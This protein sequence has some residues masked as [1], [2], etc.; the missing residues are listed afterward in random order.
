MRVHFVG[1]SDNGL[2][3]SSHN[4]QAL[5]SIGVSTAF[6]PSESKV[7]WRS[8]VWQETCRGADV[9]HVVT[10]SQCN[11]MLLRKL[12]RARM[13]GVQMVRYWV[14]S[15]C[16]WARHHGPSRRFAQALGHLGT[17][18]LT[19]ADHLVAELAAIGV[20]AHT[21]PVITPNISASVSPHPMPKEF[22]ALCYLPTRRRAF[23][24]GAVIDRLIK[25]MP[26]VRFI[27][28]G[29]AA[30][31]YSRFDNVESPG[32]VDNLART[33]G[34]SSVY[35]RPTCHDGMPRLILEA[36][37]HGRHVVASRPYPHCQHAK[38]ADE[39]QRALRHL[40]GRAEFNL[41]GRE[42]V[43]QHFETRVTAQVLGD[44]LRRCLEPGRSGLRRTGRRQ[45]VA[46]IRRTE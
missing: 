28:L 26:T 17:L 23:Y 22:A 40:E 1:E 9:I 15:D 31:D 45:A 10:Y 42:W 38:D 27:V 21:I 33:I 39:F 46:G 30:T 34:R 35:L 25:S 14:G 5:A 19:V 32:F 37:S 16:L 7:G 11:W 29:D 6:D 43:C 2:T 8:R 20:E 18:N 24:G 41:A 3:P 12:W 13:H 4:A 36:L 44:E